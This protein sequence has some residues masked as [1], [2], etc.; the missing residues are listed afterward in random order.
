[1]ARWTAADHRLAE[2][3]DGAAEGGGDAGLA[4]GGEHLARQHQRPGRGVD[5]RR[6]GMAEMPAPFGGRDLVLDEV[7]HRG[8]VGHAQERFGQA[9]QRDAFVRGEAVFGE[10]D[11]HQARAAAVPDGGDEGRAT[12]CRAGAGRGVGSMGGDQAVEKRRFGAEVVGRDA[13]A[14]GGEVDHAGLRRDGAG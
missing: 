9:H 3:A 2:A 8:R 7:V 5:Q 11:L 4:V 13:G 6:G 10:E 1:M 12:L 14:E